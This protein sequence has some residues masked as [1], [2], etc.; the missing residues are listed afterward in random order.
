MSAVTQT[1]PDW[2][3]I[4]TDY[5]AGI[6]TLRQIAAEHGITEGAIR[7]RA[8]RDEWERDLRA[9]FGS[10][11]SYNG[12]FYAGGPLGDQRRVATPDQALAEGSDLLVIGRPIT[13]DT[14]PAAAARRIAEELGA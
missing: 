3:R 14:D 1:D 5:R 6:R 4:E 10:D 8:R 12:N 2:L 13:A 9:G 7:K 11:D